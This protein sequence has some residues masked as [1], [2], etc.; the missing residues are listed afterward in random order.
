MTIFIPLILALITGVGTIFGV[1]YPIW[2]DQQAF[3]NQCELEG[4]T[5]STQSMWL[6][7]FIPA[8]AVF[9]GSM[10]VIQNHEKKKVQQA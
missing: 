8:V 4:A 7:T 10:A 9:F 6:L 2:Q 5:C 3:L 1:Q